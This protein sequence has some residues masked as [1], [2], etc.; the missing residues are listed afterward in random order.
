MSIVTILANCL[1]FY[2]KL[3]NFIGSSRLSG[4]LHY[5]SLLSSSESTNFPRGYKI[6]HTFVNKKI[7]IGFKISYE[8][9]KIIY[10][11]S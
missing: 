2:L 1:N 5:S 7:L 4:L 10:K 6:S 8:N 11:F 9:Q 3:F